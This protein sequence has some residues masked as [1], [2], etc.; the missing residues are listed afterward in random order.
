MAS[1]IYTPIS[2]WQ[3]RL[4]LLQPGEKEGELSGELKVVDIVDGFEGLILHNEQKLVE[5]EALSYTWVTPVLDD[6]IIIEHSRTPITLNLGQALRAL[7]KPDTTLYIWADALCINQADNAEKS[8]QVEKIFAIFGKA[9]AT[10]VWLG[11]QGQYAAFA[12]EVLRENLDHLRTMPADDWYSHFGRRDFS[13]RKDPPRYYVFNKPED[14][15]NED[16][17][18]LDSD[19]E[20]IDEDDVVAVTEVRSMDASDSSPHELEGQLRPLSLEHG[21]SVIKD[22]AC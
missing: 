19:D 8:W 21:G 14:C 1:S 13:V 16:G 22:A 9:Q 12:I 5:F 18:Q 4:L 11:P 3:T 7:R 6:D 20:G 15:K 10:V 17:L 2:P